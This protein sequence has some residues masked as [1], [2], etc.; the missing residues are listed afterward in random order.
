MKRKLAVLLSG[1]GSNFISIADAIERGE[2]NAE[3]VTVISNKPETPG[4]EAARAR[5]LRA[6]A[7]DHATF[8]SREVHEAAVRDALDQVSPDLI[9]LAGYMRRLTPSFVDAYP[10]RIINIHPALLPSFPG[11]DAPKQA[12]DH[13]VKVTGCTVHFVDAGVD[14]GPIIMQKAVEVLPDDTA[15]SL[16]ARLLPI[17]HQTYIDALRHLCSKPWRVEGRR[18]VL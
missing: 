11:V 17:E 8:E 4:L 7:L 9:C 14:T 12:I 3:I 5:G 2:I 16:A 15:E 13:G 6:I 18:V 1:R 10:N